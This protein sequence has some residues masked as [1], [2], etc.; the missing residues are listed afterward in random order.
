MNWTK[1]DSI[2]LFLLLLTFM[3]FVY[4]Y[5]SIMNEAKIKTPIYPRGQTQN[6]NS[7]GPWIPGDSTSSLLNLPVNTYPAYIIPQTC[8]KLMTETVCQ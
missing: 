3:I 1:I 2:L 7:V 5:I 6:V 8:Y 4:A